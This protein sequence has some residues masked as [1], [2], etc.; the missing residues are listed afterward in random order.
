MR[1]LALVVFALLIPVSASAQGSE[2]Y[3][4]GPLVRVDRSVVIATS[5]P[6]N[7]YV[8]GISVIVGS[9]RGGDLTAIA[10]TLVVAAPIT[11]DALLVTGSGN[12]RAHVGGDLRSLAGRL[13]ISKP[14]GGDLSVLAASLRDSGRIEGDVVAAALEVAL[15]GGAEGSV[16]VYGNAVT[17]GGEFDGDVHVVAGDRL[18]LLP[19]TVIHGTLAYEAPI[20]AAIP[21]SVIVEGGIAYTAADYLPGAGIS[22]TLAMASIGIFLLARI[23]ATLL[24]AGLLTGLFPSLAAAVVAEAYG[25]RERHILLV[26]LLGFAAFVAT[27]I[28]LLLLALTL[29]GAG[30]AL[31]LA[32]GYAVLVLLSLSYAGILLGGL[33]ARRFFG[34][35]APYWTDGVFGTLALSLVALIPVVGLAVLLI[36]ASFAAGALI[37]IF[38]RFAFSN[39]LEDEVL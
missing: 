31:L 9:P 3:S 39:S 21:D 38:F 25:R 15:T 8:A 2:S 26:T 30:V 37:S 19:E 20:P 11:H 24:L 1:R 29:V 18:T 32:V 13:D 33:V 23:I 35:E 16:T 7:A 6:E 28:L 4:E 12:V 22:K 14:V 10:G 5:S 36:L 34:R 17:L 27:P